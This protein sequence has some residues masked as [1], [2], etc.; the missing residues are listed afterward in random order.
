MMIEYAT[1]KLLMSKALQK[2]KHKIPKDLSD[3][4]FEIGSV[5]DSQDSFYL[6]IERWK[7]EPTI[8]ICPTAATPDLCV[9]AAFKMLGW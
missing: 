1:A 2:F 8:D 4:Y 9:E 5:S 7:K 6:R 3:M